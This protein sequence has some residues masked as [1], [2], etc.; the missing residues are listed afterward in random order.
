NVAQ[1][2]AHELGHG[3]FKLYHTFS[4]NNK[5]TL[6]P[7]STDNLMDYNNG[8]A[9]N[10]YQWDAIHNPGWSLFGN[11]F[12]DE[13][14]GAMTATDPGYY[15][16]I[17]QI[18][19]IIGS[20]IQSD[21]YVIVH[22]VK[23]TKAGSIPNTPQVIDVSSI[24]SELPVNGIRPDKIYFQTASNG[25]KTDVLNIILRFKAEKGY[26][27]LSSEINDNSYSAITEAPFLG[28][29]KKGDQSFTRCM[30]QLST[31]SEFAC[32]EP[33]DIVKQLMGEDAPALYVS[34][35]LQAIQACL[36]EQKNDKIGDQFYREFASKTTTESEKQQLRQIADVFNKMGDILFASNN[37]QTWQE[38]G[39]YLKAVYNAYKTQNEEFSSFLKRLNDYTTAFEG[40][41]D[42]IKKFKDRETVAFLIK[43]FTNEELRYLSM[44]L[45]A[46][47]LNAL[48]N[49]DLRGALRLSGYNEEETV[50]RLL[51]YVKSEEIAQLLEELKKGDLLN[52]MDEGY[53][54]LITI[55]DDN[56]AK[57]L[58]I[59]DAYTLSVKKVTDENKVEK[60]GELHE[61]NYFYNLT[62]DDLN[63]KFI[64]GSKVLKDGKVSLTISKITGYNEVFIDKMG[65]VQMP[66]TEN[67]TIEVPFDQP[68][69][70]YHNAFRK[71][72]DASMQ[73]QVE[74]VSALKLHYYL[75]CSMNEDIK[76]AASVVID[77]GFL[78]VGV[79][80]ISAGIKGGTRLVLAICN[81]SSSLTSLISTA[82]E[83]SITDIDPVNGPKFIKSLQ[84]FAAV[85]GFADLGAAGVSKLKGLLKEDVINAG[86]FYAKNEAALLKDAN[87]KAVAEQT[88]KLVDE[89]SAYDD[90]I[91]QALRYGDAGDLLAIKNVFFKNGW[92]KESILAKVKEF[93]AQGKSLAV[94]EYLDAKDI[95]EHLSKFDE[96]VSCLKLESSLSYSTIG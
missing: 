2:I 11:L 82:S 8:V 14:E 76:T 31:L 15:L 16:R 24:N 60:L 62:G 41:K 88:K 53:N 89:F 80:E 21:D 46:Q 44:S 10:K 9:L 74:I 69:A 81:I 22:T 59:I 57:L 20:E 71:G 90:E 13:E 1:T 94:T 35:V 4:S 54:D 3:A 34:K 73:K 50:L 92:T 40:K 72:V 87:S 47:C 32:G 56:Y 43:L 64:S 75:Q 30:E 42:L 52:T 51:E 5:Y 49:K 36:E 84:L 77:A 19:S 25:G 28:V 23:C 17:N 6:T 63:K 78:A 29:L 58:D 86:K 7:N 12:Q 55:A 61:Q 91:A 93:K 95:A 33:N 65:Y 67:Q 27:N 83:K 48:A 68:V 37:S 39:A 38:Q 45:R 66:I 96:G 85:T 26:Y 70:L 18:A 79:G